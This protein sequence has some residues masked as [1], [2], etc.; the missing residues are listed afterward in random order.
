MP[1]KYVLVQPTNVSKSLGYRNWLNLVQEDMGIGF[2]VD[3]SRAAWVS[4]YMKGQPSQAEI[5][6]M[7]RQM[8]TSSEQLLTAYH[9]VDQDKG[10]APLPS[11]EQKGS[12]SVPTMKK[13]DDLIEELKRKL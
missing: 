3:S 11:P 10:P 5:E 4:Q 7:A 1:R 12:G 8:L 13:G 6:K 9:K 2:G